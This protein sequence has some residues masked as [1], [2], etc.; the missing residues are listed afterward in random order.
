MQVRP[1]QAEDH[2]KLSEWWRAWGWPAVPQNCLPPLGLIVG[3]AA[4]GFFY[5]LDC[6]IALF[7]WIVADPKAEKAHRK[8]AIETLIRELEEMAYKKGYKFVYTMVK[9]QSLLHKLKGQG[10][11]ET[12]RGMTHVMKVIKEK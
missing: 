1:Y 12:D 2:K 3:E 9:S 10:F 11:I 4:A 5:E 8:E 6:D 7:E